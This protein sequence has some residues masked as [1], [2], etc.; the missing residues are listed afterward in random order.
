MNEFFYESEVS[1]TLAQQ[2]APEAQAP[3]PSPPG[4]AT[5]GPPQSNA[6]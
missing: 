4:I 2:H 3:D 6:P 5:G 1:T